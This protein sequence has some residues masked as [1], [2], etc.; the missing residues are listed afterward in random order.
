M[1]VA[2]SLI[3]E[4]L[5]Q[6]GKGKEEKTDKLDA[7]RPGT[8]IRTRAREFVAKLANHH[9]TE[10]II[11]VG[12]AGSSLVLQVKLCSEFFDCTTNDIQMHSTG[13][14]SVR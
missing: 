3:S 8:R 4:T 6:C 7:D 2:S 1:C 9:T 14:P 12:D 13:E 11:G 5:N 10:A